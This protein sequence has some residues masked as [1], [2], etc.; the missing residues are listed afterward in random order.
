MI[1][2]SVI[3]QQARTIKA[4]RVVAFA[5]LIVIATVAAIGWYAALVYLVIRATQFVYQIALA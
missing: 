1:L 3:P 5:T 4:S 2:S